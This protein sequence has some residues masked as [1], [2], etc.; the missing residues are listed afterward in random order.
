[1]GTLSADQS[2]DQGDY[3]LTLDE[4]MGT[5]D[6]VQVAEVEKDYVVSSK[7]LPTTDSKVKAAFDFSV[8]GDAPFSLQLEWPEDRFFGGD[9]AV[10]SP[11]FDMVVAK[12]DSITDVSIADKSFAGLSNIRVD[13]SSG[14]GEYV[15]FIAAAY[16]TATWLDKF[17][18]NAYAKETITLQPRSDADQVVKDMFGLCDKMTADDGWAVYKFSLGEDINGMPSLRGQGSGSGVWGFQA[19]TYHVSGQSVSSWGANAW[20]W[21]GDESL[22]GCWAGYYVSDLQC[23]GP[24][25]LAAGRARR[26]H[27]SKPERLKAVTTQHS[28]AEQEAWLRRH[29]HS[30]GL[31][32]QECSKLI[33]RLQQLGNAD[34]ISSTEDHVDPLFPNVEAS[35]APPGQMCGDSAAGISE[36]CSKYNSWKRATVVMKDASN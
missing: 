10:P 9:C 34:A 14:A 16:T 29:N 6:D 23:D 2:Q 36:S 35:I 8:S 4:F 27:R 3:W 18:V 33:E 31:G 11:Q 30:N 1:V 26:L 19:K 13:V 32:H 20:R 17:V 24:A 15:V 22:E 5:F 12:R 21:C 25:S 28:A 7:E